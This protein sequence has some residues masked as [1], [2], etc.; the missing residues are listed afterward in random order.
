MSDQ[1]RGWHWYERMEEVLEEKQNAEE[2]KQEDSSDPLKKLED[3]QK[4]LN[5]LKA[6]AVLDPRPMKV[7]RYMEAQQE[8]INRADL[9]ARIWRSVLLHHPKLDASVTRPFSKTGR[10]ILADLEKKERQQ[11]IDSL[12]KTHGLFFFFS[13]SCPW[14]HQ[15]APLV[16][17]FC[18]KYGWEV[19]PITMDGGMLPDFPYARSDNGT[20]AALGIKTLPAL[21]AVNPETG[22]VLPLAYGFQTLDQI[23]EKITLLTGNP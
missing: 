8:V 13:K 19:L 21:M 2:E 15:M 16:K 5:R 1:A 14:C 10:F 7:R 20:A 6:D 23:E 9:F 18:T 17:R 11:N 4:N 3:L 22:E 12:S